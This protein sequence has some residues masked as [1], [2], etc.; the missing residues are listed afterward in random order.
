MSSTAIVNV[1]F[2]RD[3]ELVQW[4]E[5]KLDSN[6]DL[7]AASRNLSIVV[8]RE[9]LTNI[10]SC[11]VDLQTHA[12]LKIVLAVLYLPKRNVDLWRNE[13]ED[14]LS[15]ASQDTDE[16]VQTVAELLKE[17]PTTSGFSFNMDNDGNQFTKTLQELRKT[18]E[19]AFFKIF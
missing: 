15:L 10:P 8:T 5:Q 16:W 13:I 1:D 7:W 6:D 11:F 18:R 2:L 14:V 12:K 19:C 3:R 17:Y 4:L 9:L